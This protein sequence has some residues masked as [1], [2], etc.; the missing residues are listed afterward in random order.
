MSRTLW[1]LVIIVAV[2]VLAQLYR[3]T[4]TNPPVDPGRTIQ[5]HAQVPPQVDSIL[6]RS[7]YDCHS[8]ETRYPWYSKMAPSSWLLSSDINE[9]RQNVNFS[10]W[11]AYDPA[12][13]AKKLGGIAKEVQGGDMPPWYYLPLHPP[14]KLSAADKQT[15][16]SWAKSEQAR[17]G[18]A[19]SHQPAAAAE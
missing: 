5:V 19:A 10:N 14:A 2:F 13:A 1:I 9:G 18:G 17:I 6:R 15:V 4:M 7:C 3:P 8:N 11:A 16:V 12:R